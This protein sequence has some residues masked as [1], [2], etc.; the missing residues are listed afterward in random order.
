[1]FTIIKQSGRL[2]IFNCKTI[3]RTVEYKFLLKISAEMFSLLTLAFF[4][5]LLRTVLGS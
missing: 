4:Q 2:Y 1:M 3:G 5:H